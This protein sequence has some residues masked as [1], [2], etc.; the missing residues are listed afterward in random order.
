MNGTRTL[1]ERLYTSALYPFGVTEEEYRR[2]V[3]EH[4]DARVTWR[5]TRRGQTL[6]IRGAILRKAPPR[7]PSMAPRKA[8][9]DLCLAG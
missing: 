5:V 4:R 8:P 6:H 2:W 1:D 9:P 3:L 7:A